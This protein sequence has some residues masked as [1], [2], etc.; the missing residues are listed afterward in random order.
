MCWSV[1]VQTR[2]KGKK[3]HSNATIMHR[4]L[5]NRTMA[6]GRQISFRASLNSRC[7][8]AGVALCYEASTERVV[9]DLV[10]VVDIVVVIG[11]PVR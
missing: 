9:V 5:I 10:V 7:E 11:Q 4:A 3:N 2:S 6:N 8:L 1:R